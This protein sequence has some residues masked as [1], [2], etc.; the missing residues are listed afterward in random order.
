M[1]ARAGLGAESPHAKKCKAAPRTVLQ[2][3]A[4][5]RIVKT[6]SAVYTRDAKLTQRDTT[7]VTIYTDHLAVKAAYETEHR[8]DW[9]DDPTERLTKLTARHKDTIPYL[10]DTIVA[11]LTDEHNVTEITAELVTRGHITIDAFPLPNSKRT[12]HNFMPS[13]KAY[14]KAV[15]LAAAERLNEQWEQQG[16]LVHL[17]SPFAITVN[18]G[19]RLELEEDETPW[20]LDGTKFRGPLADECS[21][22][23]DQLLTAQCKANNSFK[24]RVRRLGGRALRTLHLKR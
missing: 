13:R 10:A 23:L 12:S 20:G 4:P 9:M 15:M 5:T 16:V 24:K 17:T 6:E 19:L 7:Y 8:D 11:T 18:G 14:T 2:T 22:I 21:I 3:D 1:Q